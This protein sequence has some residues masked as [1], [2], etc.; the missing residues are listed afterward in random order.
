MKILVN[1]REAV[2]KAGSSFEYVSE[3]PLFTEAEDYTLEIE[4][5]MKD[6]PQNILIFGALHVKGVDI[7]TLS[8]PCEIVTESFDKAGFLTITEVND[9]LVK[10]QFLEGMSTGRFDSDAL[11]L[12]IDEFDY[13]DYD[14]SDETDTSVYRAMGSGWAP[15]VVWDSKKDRMYGTGQMEQDVMCKYVRHVSLRKLI[16]LVGI[17]SGLSVDM[18]ALDAIPFFSSIIVA[19]STYNHSGA[20][21]FDE[22]GHIVSGTSYYVY[23]HFMDLEKC[24]PHWTVKDF[25][26][27]VGRFFGCLVHTDSLAGTVMFVPY[28]NYAYGMSRVSLPVNDDFTVEMQDGAD[29]GYGDL[30]KVK[31][32]D[33]CNPNN[34]NQCNWFMNNLDKVKVES[35]YS[36]NDFVYQATHR[37]THVDP[38]LKQRYIYQ[39]NGEK[40]ALI[41][42]TEGKWD[43]NYV[44]EFA[45]IEPLN[46]YGSMPEDGKELKVIPCQ[47]VYKSLGLGYV[48]GADVYRNRCFDERGYLSTGELTHAIAYKFPVMEVQQYPERSYLD[49]KT[50]AWDLLQGGEE[51][52][53]NK[54]EKLLIVL[55]SGTMESD[56]SH[57]NTRQKE[58]D[59]GT[60]YAAET[61]TAMEGKVP[62]YHKGVKSYTYSLAPTESH[63]AANMVLPNVNETKLYRYKFLSKSL[64]DPKA[65]Y[66]IKSKEYACLRLIAHFTVDGM[67]E[68]IEG[69]FYE[70]VG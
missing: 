16:E 59:L 38:V 45:I 41:E 69:E 55:H 33:D 31:F 68:L 42:M 46:Q 53:E 14:G 67:S 19:N 7:S 65:I 27:E 47:M 9:V 63:I 28:K 34:V 64:P 49:G 56:G 24:L 66:V 61:V 22:N 60:E 57:V 70:I 21:R 13:S 36:Y 23:R 15:L 5:P 2:L 1:G 48:P 26:T 17:K 62:V 52:Y 11:K 29:S 3:N 50:D 44:S 43:D 51:K 37:R 32:P 30:V 35:L 8:F 18:S 54:F 10:G 25:M 39:I 58:P 12:Y 4:F 20:V 40:V 6:C